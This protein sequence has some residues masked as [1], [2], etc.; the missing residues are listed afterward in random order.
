MLKSAM[1]PAGFLAACFARPALGT[2]IL[3]SD[4]IHLIGGFNTVFD[5]VPIQF[6][7]TRDYRP[8]FGERFPI[9]GTSI[10]S[11][12]DVGRV[13]TIG[14]PSTA[15][16]LE[17][18]GDDDLFGAFGVK[19][20]NFHPDN[21]SSSIVSTSEV[22]LQVLGNYIPLLAQETDRINF[23]L[24]QFK[25]ESPG[26]DINGDGV[27]TNYSIKYRIDFVIAPPPASC[28]PLLIAGFYPRRRSRRSR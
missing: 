13:W 23:T 11:E 22:Y 26:S 14:A 19:M 28:A 24:L 3:A 16:I 7:M 5:S 17:E 2:I 15:A 6:V 10:V 1:L 4:E 27:W 25:A 20:T 8:G 9:S 18:L 12:A 21:D